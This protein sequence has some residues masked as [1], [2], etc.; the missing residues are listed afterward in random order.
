MEG[1]QLCAEREERGA[2][3]GGEF[4]A[5]GDGHCLPAALDYFVPIL[6]DYVEGVA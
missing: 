4:F 6:V 5:V 3:G 1:E 2:L